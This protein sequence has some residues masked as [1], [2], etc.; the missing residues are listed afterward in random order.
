VG[1]SDGGVPGGGATRE[2]VRGPAIRDTFARTP[3]NVKHGDTGDI[4][5]VQYHRLERDLD[6]LVE[7][8]IPAYRFS[9]VWPRILPD[10]RGR[11]NQ[12]GLDYYA[13]LVDGLLARSITP[14]LALYHWDLPQAL[15]EAGGWTNRDTA[16][17]SAYAAR[18][19][20]ALG[21]RVPFWITLNE[22]WCSAFVGH[23]EGH[24]A[25][26]RQDEAAALA[27]AHH[28][29]LA[30]GRAVE[31]LRAHGGHGGWASRST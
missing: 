8:G 9:V 7:L 2:D 21:D 17:F 30:H 6:L 10:G 29:Q 28:L 31:A 14:M 3:G 1:H 20:R 24:H 26:G 13:R 11:V 25:P 19:Y 22:P 5:C 16:A 27:A 15:Q 23:L 4:A 18:V 12:P